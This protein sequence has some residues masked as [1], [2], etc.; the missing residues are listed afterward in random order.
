MAEETKKQ[1]P[2]KAPKKKAPK[3][4]KQRAVGFLNCSYT[5][6]KNEVVKLKGIAVFG[7]GI[8]TD[9]R[10]IHLV[11]VAKRQG[12]EITVPMMVTIRVNGEIEL[13]EDSDIPL[14]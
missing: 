11:E 4:E 7:E 12:G 14:V 3:K 8:Y 13:P 2:A 6:K 5:T 9:P 10:S 1:R